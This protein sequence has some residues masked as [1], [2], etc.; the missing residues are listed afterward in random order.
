[1]T[2]NDFFKYHRN[3]K[4]IERLANELSEVIERRH[5]DSVQSAIVYVQ[6]HAYF[7]TDNDYQVKAHI[8]DC[9]AMDIMPLVVKETV[10]Q[11]TIKAQ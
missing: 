1:M 3:Q 4:K 7:P 10:Q 11:A 8:D 5:L 6:D 9:L 2:L